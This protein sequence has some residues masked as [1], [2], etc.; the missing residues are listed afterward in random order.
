MLRVIARLQSQGQML[1]KAIKSQGASNFWVGG[2]V[3]QKTIQKIGF[4]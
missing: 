1:A 4:L 3:G 2:S